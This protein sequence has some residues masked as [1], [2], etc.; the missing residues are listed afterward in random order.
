MSEQEII[1]GNKLI[2]EFMNINS[3]KTL[4]TLDRIEYCHKN[5]W[6]F[7]DEWWEGELEFHKSFDLLMPVV[8]KIEK[9]YDNHHGYFGVYI[10]SNSCSIQGT[11]LHLALQNLNNY[12]S[13]YF[14]EVK[15]NTKIE[16][17]WRAVVEFIKWYN[18]CQ[19]EK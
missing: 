1:E 4:S 19:K 15:L 11:K 7:N 10:S 18:S 8:E 16:A 6:M 9:I 14:N 17:T 3:D 5:V 12:G 13:V 2:C